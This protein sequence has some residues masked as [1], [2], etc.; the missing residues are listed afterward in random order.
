MPMR[1]LATALAAGLLVTAPAHAL[2]KNSPPA[3]RISKGA[4]TSHPTTPS[5]DR[6]VAFA[7]SGDLVGTGNTTRQV[8]LFNLFAHDCDIG[9]IVIGCPLPAVPPIRQITSGPG[10]PDNPTINQAGTLLAFDALGSYGGGTG[11][12]AA[13]RQIFLLNL[14]T[15]DLRRVTNGTDG[16]SV[17][18]S[19]SR[20]GGRMVFESSASLVGPSGVTQIYLYETNLGGLQR[21][22]DGAAPSTNPALNKLASVVA[23]E[24]RARHLGDGSDSGISQIF[25]YDVKRSRLHQ[26]TNGNGPS[27]HPA[28]SSAVKSKTLRRS[29]IRRVAI[30]FDST[31]TNLPGTAGGP[32]RQAY[33]GSVDLGDLPNLVQLTPI[34]VDGCTPSSPG[35]SSYPTIDPTG[36]RIAFISTGDFLCNGT[37]GRRAFVTDMRRVPAV[38]YQMTGRGDVQGPLSNFLG[39][40]FLTLSTNDDLTGQGVCGHQLQ[41][42]DYF[43]GRWS[44][45]T[46][47]GQTP[48]EPIPGNPDAGCDD[49]NPCTADTCGPGGVCKNTPI[50]CP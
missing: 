34:P 1:Y 50:A 4:P 6:Y 20:A 42:I 35:E 21:L 18:P 46:K 5:W 22:T 31:A 16:D 3:I 24:S 25:W 13:R 41:V 8:F 12:A 26:L 43:T 27:T 44:P 38:L 17:R 32:G 33:V 10:A 30:L 48:L 37:T 23:F 9:G 14:A 2:H 29:G 47:V 7:S 40:W 39:L 15:G 49:G 28:V 19:L 45:A 36:R 11:P